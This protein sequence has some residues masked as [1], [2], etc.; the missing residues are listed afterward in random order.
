MDNLNKWRSDVNKQLSLPVVRR[1]SISSVAG[2]VEDRFEAI[3][4][5]RQRGMPWKAIAAALDNGD[6]IKVD[7]VESAFKRICAEH[8]VPIPPRLRIKRAVSKVSN[9]RPQ[10]DVGAPEINL[11]GESGERWVDDGE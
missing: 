11:F 3:M 4:E 8:G 1:R 10:N 7:A 9:I 5:A 2:R 6:Q